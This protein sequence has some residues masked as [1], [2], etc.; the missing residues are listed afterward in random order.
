ME[1]VPE[2]LLEIPNCI[3]DR[4]DGTKNV[5]AHWRNSQSDF[6]DSGEFLKQSF[7]I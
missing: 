4:V 3:D 5:V 1:T 7:A 2:A 6:A